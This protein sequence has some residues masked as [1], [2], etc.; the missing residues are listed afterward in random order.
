MAGSTL[1][2]L[3]SHEGARIFANSPRGGN[4]N[5][6]LE[7]PLTVKADGY[8]LEDTTT[9]E[10]KRSDGM[11]NALSVGLNL[12]TGGRGASQQNNKAMAVKLS[13]ENFSESYLRM[14]GQARDAFV[15][16]LVSA[17]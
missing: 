14:I 10:S 7:T 12:L 11:A 8:A 6:W 15:E 1:V 5:I 13:E 4:A 2:Q 3:I 17:R 16:K 9:A